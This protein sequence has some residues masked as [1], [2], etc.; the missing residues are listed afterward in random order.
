MALLSM[1]AMHGCMASR[2]C[3]FMSGMDKTARRDCNWGRLSSL[4]PDSMPSNLHAFLHVLLRDRPIG[5]TQVRA[6]VDL[7]TWP[8]AGSTLHG[9]VPHTTP[10]TEAAG[11]TEQSI[12][13]LQV[14]G[15]SPGR[16]LTVLSGM[17]PGA[18]PLP[19]RQPLPPAPSPTA[20]GARSDSWCRS[21]AQD[22]RGRGGH[23]NRGRDGHD[24]RQRAP[25]LFAC[26]LPDGTTHIRYIISALTL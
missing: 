2:A 8:S 10:T 1:P 20:A 16:C 12:T 5:S 9:M 23:S 15:S 13:L 7:L 21:P 6:A 11:H 18:A 17:K 4:H 24:D 22:K 25:D 3:W 26:S 19:W 14:D